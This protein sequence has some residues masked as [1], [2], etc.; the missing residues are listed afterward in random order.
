VL[1]RARS[2][3]IGLILDTDQAVVPVGIASR[4][5]NVALSTAAFVLEKSTGKR[6]VEYVLSTSW[7]AVEGR[8]PA[9]GS[10][11]PN[12]TLDGRRGNRPLGDRLPFSELG[13][14]RDTD[15]IHHP[16]A[17]AGTAELAAQNSG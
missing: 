10:S 12:R 13:A 2:R 16:V 1:S 4:L 14:G 5:A 9:A 11:R 8:R 3:E 6:R 17:V 7:M 15:D